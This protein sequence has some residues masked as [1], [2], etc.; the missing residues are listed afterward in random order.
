MGYS[1]AVDGDVIEKQAYKDFLRASFSAYEIFWQKF[2]VPLTG[3]PKHIFFK[4]DS[5]LR[6]MFPNEGLKILHERVCIAQLHYSVLIFLTNAYTSS[7]NAGRDFQ[8]LIRFF[9]NLYSA[10]D[11]STELF[12]RY[13]RLVNKGKISKDAFAANAVAEEIKLR[14]DWRQPDSS[15]KNCP[16]PNA[17][18]KQIEKIR[19]YRNTLIHGRLMFQGVMPTSRHISVP[20]LGCERAFLD[21]REAIKL[22]Q[23]GKLGGRIW[24][25]NLAVDTFKTTVEYLQNEWNKNLIFSNPSILSGL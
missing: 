6:D 23:E 10:L 18:P 9:S 17:Y 19:N 4:D 13:D 8:E 12:A 3:R 15:Q 16:N 7:R 14:C 22:H 21:W 2:V 5:E 1:L 20:A 24:A 25:K 11:V